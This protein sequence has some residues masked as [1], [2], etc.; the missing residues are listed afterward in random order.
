MGR[1]EGTWRP[2]HL[3]HIMTTMHSVKE[4]KQKDYCHVAVCPPSSV[5]LQATAVRDATT[6]LFPLG[7]VSP[8]SITSY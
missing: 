8:L 1:S 3:I 2:E 7:R 4:A 6:F 5:T